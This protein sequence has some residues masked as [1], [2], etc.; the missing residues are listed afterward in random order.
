ME[1]QC[2]IDNHSHSLSPHNHHW[3]VRNLLHFG[4][5]I[6][7]V[8]VDMKQVDVDMNIDDVDMNIFDV[9][10]LQP[11]DA[12]DHLPASLPPF[13]KHLPFYQKPIT[14]FFVR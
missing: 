14:Y 3:A 6:D 13:Q 2:N 12:P 11:S 5:D 1:A 10:I 4:V 9:D 7:Q 8:E